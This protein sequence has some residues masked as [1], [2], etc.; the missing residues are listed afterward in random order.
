[1]STVLNHRDT[2]RKK[3]VKHIAI[4]GNNTKSKFNLAFDLFSP[5][6]DRFR[7]GSGQYGDF[8]EMV[9]V[10]MNLIKLTLNFKPNNLC[11]PFLELVST[12]A[13]IAVMLLNWPSTVR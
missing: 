9:L 2:K 7:G 12:G 13:P 11:M 1:M 6:E 10:E 5:S 3:K 4:S 8:G